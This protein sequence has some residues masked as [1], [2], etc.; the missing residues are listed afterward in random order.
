MKRHAENREKAN[1]DRKARRNANLELARAKDRE[2]RKANREKVSKSHV[3]TRRKRRA[4]DPLF[5]I[6]HRVRGLVSRSISDKGFK[7]GS[8]TEA[9]LGC[10]WEELIDHIERQFLKG[11][12]WENRHLWHIDHIIP[13]ST[14]TT[15]EDVISLN[16]VSNLRPMWG[17]ENISK[18][19]KVL[20]LI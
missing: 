3:A 10:S 13:L 4:K 14:A 1:A 9:I 16:H 15:E 7:K 17:G 12:T 5:A 20:F 6:K 18:S 8:K 2:Y 11:M 19:D